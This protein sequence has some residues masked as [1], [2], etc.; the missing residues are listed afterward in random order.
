MTQKLRP[1]AGG[2]AAR[3]H[4]SSPVPR[5]E[6]SRNKLLLWIAIGVIVVLG[7]TAVLVRVLVPT[8]KVW[9]RPEAG[10]VETKTVQTVS[11]P[12]VPVREVAPPP[13]KVV[14]V[15][16]P[17]PA[18]NAVVS[19]PSA[20]LRSSPSLKVHPMKATV[21]RNERITILKRVPSRSGPDWVQIR[22]GSGRVGW[23]WASLVREYRG[24]KGG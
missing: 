17:G 18:P 5:A 9:H 15:E 20:G 12:A 23:I 10:L 13:K 3:K 8:Q 11:A 21:K 14:A 4:L 19:V 2:P 7:V 1:K 22:T 16:K 6:A 24:G